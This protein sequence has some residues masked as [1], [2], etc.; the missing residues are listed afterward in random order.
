MNQPCVR[1]RYFHV[2][3]CVHL[4]ERADEVPVA[5]RRR[6]ARERFAVAVGQHRRADAVRKALRVTADR[7]DVGVPRD[8]PEGIVGRVFRDRQ[9]RV[10]ARPGQLFVKRLPRGIGGGVDD[11]GGNLSR[12]YRFCHETKLPQEWPSVEQD[13]TPVELRP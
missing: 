10:G 1:R 5:P 4:H 2:I 3:R 13:W 6:V 12:Q 7:H 11:R 8:E 9:G